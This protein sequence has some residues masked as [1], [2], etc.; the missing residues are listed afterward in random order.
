[1]GWM[2]GP[3][4]ESNLPVFGLWRAIFLQIDFE[5]SLE[6]QASLELMERGICLR[7]RE[8]R[9]TN[10]RDLFRSRLDQIIDKLTDRCQFDILHPGDDDPWA[11]GTRCAESVRRNARR[12]G[13]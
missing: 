7:P 10:E 13:T 9:E 5:E 8:R 4:Q 3:G 2:I 12:A 1:M 6:S 11:A